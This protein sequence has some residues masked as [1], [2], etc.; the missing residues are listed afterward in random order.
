LSVTRSGTTSTFFAN[1][2]GALTP[3]LHKLEW[4]DDTHF[5]LALKPV[6][7]H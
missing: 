3:F 6:K 7:T 4:A 1:I 2:N 5:E